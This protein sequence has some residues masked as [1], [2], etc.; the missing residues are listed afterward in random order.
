MQHVLGNLVSITKGCEYP[1]PCR[2]KYNG[3]DALKSQ[4]VDDTAENVEGTFAA[5]LK[6]AKELAARKWERGVYK[7]LK[8][9]SGLSNLFL[10]DRH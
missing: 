7:S 8:V 9:G 4:L 1:R 3:R 6:K 2:T 5:A 10:S